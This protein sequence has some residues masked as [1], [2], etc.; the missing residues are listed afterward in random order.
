MAYELTLQN[1]KDILCVQVSGERTLQTLV[2]IAAEAIDMCQEKG[3]KKILINLQG[4]QGCLRTSEIYDLFT[5]KLRHLIAL[6]SLRI[7]IVNPMSNIHNHHFAEIVAA[8]NGYNVRIFCDMNQA[9]EWLLQE[10]SACS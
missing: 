3:V 5:E 8:N 1:E 2:G 10:Q 9:T 4:L 6:H 7:S